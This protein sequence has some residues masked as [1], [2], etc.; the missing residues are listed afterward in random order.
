M[1]KFLEP[2][3]VILLGKILF[4]D[5]ILLRWDHSGIPEWVLSPVISVFM[6]RRH[7]HTEEKTVWRWRQ[8]LEWCGH[9]SRKPR[10]SDGH[11]KTRNRENVFLRA[12]RKSWYFDFSFQACRS[13][14]E[15]FSLAFSHPTCGNLF[16]N[17]W[18]I[19]ASLCLSSPS[20]HSCIILFP[21][22]PLTH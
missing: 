12:S 21:L 4:A 11:Q 5:V 6:R 8:R 18:E 14:Q 13:E 15:Y 2:V 3:N 16:Q 10:N 1:S 9:K 22:N 17:P 20:L 7:R 19:H